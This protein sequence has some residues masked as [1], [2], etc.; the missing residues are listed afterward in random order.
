MQIFFNV[1]WS[2]A[3]FWIN[4]Y[5]CVRER[6][7]WEVAIGIIKPNQLMYSIEKGEKTYSLKAT[8]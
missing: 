1:R 8:E 6:W 5:M 7:K 2:D 3:F 4:I